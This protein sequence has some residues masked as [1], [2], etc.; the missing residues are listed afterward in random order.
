MEPTDWA[1]EHSGALRELFALRLSFARIA[2]AINRKFNTAYSR[3]A[4]LSRAR[5]MGLAWNDRTESSPCGQPR[6]SRP[7]EIHLVKSTS[8]RFPWPMPP[9]RGT[10]PVRL[11]CVETEPLH[12]SLIELERG[13][14]RYPYGGDEEGEAITFCGHPGRPGSSYCTPHFHLSRG[15]GTPSERT[16]C[17]VLL[18]LV[19]T[20]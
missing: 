14:C 12:L 5:R 1:P 20:A 2:A 16:A 8:P 17:T 13:N 19:E 3:N 10:K 4:V 7:S 6:L 18:K 11:R 15:P 9:F